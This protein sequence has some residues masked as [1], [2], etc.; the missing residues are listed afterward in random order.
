MEQSPS[1]E[2]N[3]PSAS[4]EI[5]RILWKPK[6]HYRVYK[7]RPLVP[8]QSQINPVRAPSIPLSEDLSQYYPP[9]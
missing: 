2:A 8:I 1:K 9:I 5:H 6:V 7:C 3:R 4:Q